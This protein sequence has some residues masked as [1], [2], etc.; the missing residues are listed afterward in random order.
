MRL[1][2]SVVWYGSSDMDRLVW[3]VSI[4]SVFRVCVCDA[5]I[6]DKKKESLDQSYRSI[7]RSMTDTDERTNERTDGRTDPI[8]RS[9]RLDPMHRSTRP[10]TTE[11]DRRTGSNGTRVVVVVVVASRRRAR[12]RE[13]GAMTVVKRTNRCATVA[14]GCDRSTRARRTNERTKDAN[15]DADASGLGQIVDA[16]AKCARR[17]TRR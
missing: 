9:T 4:V 1:D 13:G 10:K 11:D 8:H 6:E 12:K 5:S 14:F 17:G 15:A 16:R 3:I 2:R 7:D